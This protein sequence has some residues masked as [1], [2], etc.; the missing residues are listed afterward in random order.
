MTV[1]SYKLILLITLVGLACVSFSLSLEDYGKKLKSYEELK[2]RGRGNRDRGRDRFTDDNSE[3]FDFDD[4]SSS[5]NNNDEEITISKG[6]ENDPGNSWESVYDVNNP[7]YVHEDD[8]K[9]RDRGRNRADN[10][11]KD[12]ENVYE[13]SGTRDRTVD[14]PYNHNNNHENTQQQLFGAA[15]NYNNNK[16]DKQKEDKPKVPITTN[17]ANANTAASMDSY[18]KNP[19]ISYSFPAVTAPDSY[20][21][22]AAAPVAGPYSAQPV[23]YAYPTATVAQ[24]PPA[25]AAYA[26]PAPYAGVGY[27]IGG[28][29]YGGGYASGP[30][31]AAGYYPVPAGGYGGYAAPYPAPIPV[32]T[33]SNVG[34]SSF[35]GGSGANF[36]AAGGDYNKFYQSTQIYSNQVESEHFSPHSSYFNAQQNPSFSYNG[37]SISN[38]PLGY[39]QNAVG[40]QQGGGGSVNYGQ[41]GFNYDKFRQNTQAYNNEVLRENYNPFYTYGNVWNGGGYSG[42]NQA[43][44]AIIY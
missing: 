8:Y 39:G 2:A 12:W 23:A 5:H 27:P 35:N 16:P 28:G 30:Y 26:T 4:G 36:G 11:N 24:V 43:N 18:N 9:N 33:G 21:G 7:N 34:A 25:G 3:D 29:G 13:N 6:D 20:I 32:A 44:N 42:F 37:A 41:N 10:S 17:S 38:G 15:V 31:S 19:G 22:V 14:L 1:I 40:V